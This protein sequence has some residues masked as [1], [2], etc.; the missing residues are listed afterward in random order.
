MRPLISP[1]LLAFF[2]LAAQF[3]GAASKETKAPEQTSFCEDGLHQSLSVESI[4]L[5]S[6]V[7]KAVMDTQQGKQARR[8]AKGQGK[9]LS[10]Q[11]VLKGAKVHLAGS[12]GSYFV[13]VGSP[14][15]SGADNTWF[16][17]V[18]LSKGRASVLLYTGATCIEIRRTR[19]HG[20]R[21]ITTTWSSASFTTIETYKFNG[22]KYVLW[23][24]TSKPTRQ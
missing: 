15:M 3:A 24:R 7:M 13:V 14:P 18:E 12:G 8:D 2:L 23:H 1:T 20:H 9:H 22:R 4:L 21:D 19:T 10:P 17:I 11:E 5:P 16:W 6:S